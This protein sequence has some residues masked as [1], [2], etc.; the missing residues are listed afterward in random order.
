MTRRTHV[1]RLRVVQVMQPSARKRNAPLATRRTNAT[2]KVHVRRKVHAT[3]KASAVMSAM[4]A[5]VRL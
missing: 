4:V 1:V 5:T 2:R 3:R